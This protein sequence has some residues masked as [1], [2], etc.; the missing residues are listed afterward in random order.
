MGLGL[1]VGGM[2]ALGIVMMVISRKMRTALGAVLIGVIAQVLGNQVG[3]VETHQLAML[4]SRLAANATFNALGLV[5]GVALGA[6]IGLAISLILR[7][8][9]N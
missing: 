7:A 8:R 3:T 9:S 4:I 6:A 1:V 5:L 2:T